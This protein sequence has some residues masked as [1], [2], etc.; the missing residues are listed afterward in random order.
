MNGKLKL[1]DLK[2][3]IN[4]AESELSRCIKSMQENKQVWKKYIYLL[5]IYFLKVS[6]SS[7]YFICDAYNEF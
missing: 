3:K 6:S 2:N 4:H 7:F 1:K 5:K